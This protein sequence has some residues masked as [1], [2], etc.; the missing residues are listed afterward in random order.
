M[1]QSHPSIVTTFIQPSC[2]HL[3]N[4][5]FILYPCNHIISIPSTQPSIYPFIHS[6]SIYSI[7]SHLSIHSTIPSFPIHS[8]TVI[9]DPDYPIVQLIRRRIIAIK[10]ME[11]INASR[12]ECG[13]Q[14]LQLDFRIPLHEVKCHKFFH[15]QTAN[16]FSGRIVYYPP[17]S[18]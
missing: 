11:S 1:Q 13:C 4:S 6:A 15:P 9:E 14:L 3:F 7:V 18:L 8:S 16:F 10:I 2:A 17:S 12:V 5:I